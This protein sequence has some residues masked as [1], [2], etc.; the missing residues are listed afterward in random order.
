MP[1]TAKQELGILGETLV[2]KTCFC[3]KCKRKGTLKRL[4]TNFKCA[5]IICDFC[6]YLAQV[7]ATTVKDVDHVP[8]TILGAAW[9]PQAE[10]M[11]SGI[12]FS[13]FL[14][15]V[16][17]RKKAIY[18]IPAD[19]QKVEMFKA[20]KPLSANARRAGWQGFI[21]DLKT[22]KHALIRLF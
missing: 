22:N 9:G 1:K 11:A 21:Y 10:R 2:A 18:Y 5:D 7:K 14:V 20:R 17:G 8:H 19:L 12:Y 4:P 15:L 6:G 16:S 3:P 13:L